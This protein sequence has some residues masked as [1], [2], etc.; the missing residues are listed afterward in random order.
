MPVA[1]PNTS[2]AEASVLP[3]PQLGFHTQESWR[4]HR[5]ITRTIWPV[6]WI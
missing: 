1:A 5:S 6:D 3:V 2:G 4:R